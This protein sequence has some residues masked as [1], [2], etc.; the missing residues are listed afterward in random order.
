MKMC[1]ITIEGF[2]Q[3]IQERFVQYGIKMSN[4]QRN[5]TRIKIRIA[6]LISN[7]E[8]KKILFISVQVTNSDA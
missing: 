7:K 5:L 3:I 1:F 4:C 8:G 2:N 6:V